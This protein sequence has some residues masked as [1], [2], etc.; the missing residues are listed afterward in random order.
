MNAIQIV[1]C[2]VRTESAN[3]VQFTVSKNTGRVG[4]QSTAKK[5][6][7]NENY[8]VDNVELPS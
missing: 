3:I 8:A 4:S 7:L 6:N 1:V 5:G 2:F